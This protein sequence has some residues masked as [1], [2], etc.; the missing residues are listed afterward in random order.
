VNVDK[1]IVDKTLGPIIE[2]R[3]IDLGLG[4]TLAEMECAEIFGKATP[5]LKGLQQAIDDNRMAKLLEKARDK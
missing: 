2:R 3:M 1:D 4:I 5:G